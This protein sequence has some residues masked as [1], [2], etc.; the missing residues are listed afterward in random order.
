MAT[1]SM[2]GT[3]ELVAECYGLDGR[4]FQIQISPSVRVADCA[5]LPFRCEQRVSRATR[6]KR[7]NGSRRSRGKGKKKKVVQQ[8]REVKR[9]DGEAGEGN[10]RV[11]GRMLI[12]SPF[13]DRL[14]PGAAGSSARLL[15]LWERGL[16]STVAD[17]MTGP[18]GQFQAP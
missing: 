13:H 1:S 8:E 3:K 4:L 7:T 11:R 16:V 18:V 14:Q 15:L 17:M 10:V 2:S 5:R 6:A 12:F 9:E